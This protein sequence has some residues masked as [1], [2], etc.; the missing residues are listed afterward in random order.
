MEHRAV[1][2][3]RRAVSQLRLAVQLVRDTRQAL[4]RFPVRQTLAS[5]HLACGTNA[6]SRFD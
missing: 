2:T 1:I 4:G 6:A 3:S 5:M